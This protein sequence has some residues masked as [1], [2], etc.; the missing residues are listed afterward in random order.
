[1]L[2]RRRGWWIVFRKEVRE[3][4]RD[5]RALG[6]AL[7]Y[8]PLFGPVLFALLTSFIVGKQLDDAEKPIRLAVLGAEQ[9]PNFVGFLRQ[10]GVQI[11]PA[12]ADAEAAIREQAEDV[13]L[14]IPDSYA[15]DWE[16]GRPARI[17]LLADASRQ[18]TRTTI[19]RVRGLLDRYAGQIARLRLQLRGLDPQ[20]GS[21]LLV[22][23]RDFSTTQ[24]RGA[25]LLAML[26]YFLILCAFLGGMYLAIDA[27]A[28]ERE[29]QSLEPLLI[30]PVPPTQI[31]AGKLA[32]T[33]VFALASVISCVLAFKLGLPYIRT[34][35]LGFGLSI[36]PKA[37]LQMILLI[38]PVTVLAAAVQT[39]IASFARSFREAQTYLQ[40][41]MIL[42]AIP[43]L[44]L[45]LSP[46]KALPWMLA[47]PLLSQSLLINE[48]A[49]GDR[50]ASG[51]IALSIGGTLLAA[52][53]AA[54][55]AVRLYRG[56]RLALA[57]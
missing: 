1:M 28:G 55:V 25:T 34:E 56:E 37:A 14:A 31:M 23:M 15:A 35:E 32:A 10:Q 9:A 45:T 47:T 48:L 13:I 42:P 49:R 4:L 2:R 19:A 6:M 21:P 16:A 20:L 7:L 8:G 52:L 30:N 29:R 18:Q 11:R 3:N 39:I 50:L 53:A 38:A 5:R 17:E 22:A 33:A 54:L 44:L 36:S 41:L 27:T 51:D 57:V 12:P 40:F 24:S 26:P 43:G 46:I